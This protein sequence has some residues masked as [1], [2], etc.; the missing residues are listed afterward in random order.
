MTG[1]ISPDLTRSNCTDFYQEFEDAVSTFGL[2]TAVLIVTA[3]DAG[4]APTA[5]NDIILFH[6]FITKIMVESQCEIL[7]ADKY[8]AD[9][10]HYPTANYS[11]GLNYT[12]KQSEIAQ[13]RLRYKML[14]LWIK[15]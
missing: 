1:T 2:K 6:P 13:Q 10:G 8:G 3:R 9:L 5:V 14:G 7:W 4:H 12:A 11:A 15:N